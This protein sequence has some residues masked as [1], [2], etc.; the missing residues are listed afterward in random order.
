MREAGRNVE[1]AAVVGAELHQHALA[2]LVALPSLILAQSP[3]FPK[4]NNTQNPK[5]IPPT[6]AETV[7]KI[8][9]PQAPSNPDP[10]FIISAAQVGK[11]RPMSTLTG[12]A[13]ESAIAPR[14]TS[15]VAGIAFCV[16]LLAAG[17]A[18]YAFRGK[19]FK[20]SEENTSKATGAVTWISWLTLL[21]TLFCLSH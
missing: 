2:G 8:V 15:V 16:L 10:K 6:P 21:F 19:L 14:K 1:H 18:A 12:G 13:S 9:V 7:Q 3:D 20:S 4:I 5:D 11:A 17:G